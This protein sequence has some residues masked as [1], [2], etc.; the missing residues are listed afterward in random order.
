MNSVILNLGL[1]CVFIRY[2]PDHPH[3]SD[4]YKQNRLMERLRYHLSNKS[5]GNVLEYLFYPTKAEK[6][7][8]IT[9]P[10]SE[11][12]ESASEPESESDYYFT[13]L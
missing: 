7:A 3:F 2:N 9:E 8:D 13:C 12:S 1:E 6:D 4:R 11:V 5:D 10:E